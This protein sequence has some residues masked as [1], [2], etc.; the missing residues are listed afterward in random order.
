M[1]GP[2]PAPYETW[3]RGGFVPHFCPVWHGEGLI[4]PLPI[5]KA[6]PASRRVPCRN[7]GLL[8]WRRPCSRLTVNCRLACIRLWWPALRPA[9]TASANFCII[10]VSQLNCTVRWCKSCVLLCVT[11]SMTQNVTQYVTWYVLVDLIIS[12][13]WRVRRRI[14]C[15]Q[16]FVN[17]V[18]PCLQT[19][20]AVWWLPQTQTSPDIVLPL[21]RQAFSS[22]TA[23]REAFN[24]QLCSYVLSGLELSNS[25]TLESFVLFAWMSGRGMNVINAVLCVFCEVRAVTKCVCII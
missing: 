21:Q 9:V 12:S 23:G 5:R 7:T 6:L 15:V 8:Y 14:F 1:I 16:K 2:L 18:C 11:K 25:I 13:S 20:P 24:R 4:A 10:L 22:G 19:E 3:Q 17:F